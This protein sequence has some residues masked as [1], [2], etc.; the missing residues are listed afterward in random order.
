MNK[1][2]IFIISLSVILVISLVLSLVVLYK[3]SNDDIIQKIGD[4]K[5]IKGNVLYEADFSKF[6]ASQTLPEGYDLAIPVFSENETKTISAAITKDEDK[7]VLNLSSKKS[8]AFLT[9]PEIKTQDYIFEAELVIKTEENATLGIVND[10]QGG[11]SVAKGATICVLRLNKSKS[12]WSYYSR[13]VEDWDGIEAESLGHPMDNPKNGDRVKLKLVSFEN[14]NYLFVND[15]LIATYPQPVRDAKT[16]NVGFFLSD[17]QVNIEKV[18]ITSAC[19][20]KFNLNETAFNVNTDEKSTGLTFSASFDKNNDFYKASYSKNYYYSK[21]TPIKFGFFLADNTVEN[22]ES[23]SETTKNVQSIFFTEYTENDSEINFTYTLNNIPNDMFDKYYT[24]RAFALVEDE[25]FYFDTVSFSV[26]RLAN[27]AFLNAN[28]EEREIINTKFNNVK[29]FNSTG[30]KSI[31]F[32]L[33]SDLHYKE[34]MYIS[35]IGDLNYI[36]ERAYNNHASFVISAGDMTNDMIGSPELVKAF[37]NNKYGLGAYNVYGNHE[38]E[39]SGNTMEIVTPTL[40]NDSNAIF[41]TESGKVEDG[42]I[43]YYYT[44]REGFRLI[45]LDSNYYIDP[46]TN[47]WVHNPTAYWGPLPGGIRIQSLGPQQLAWLEKVLLDAAEKDIPCIVTAHNSFSGKIGGLSGDAEAVRAL[48]KKANTKNPGTVIMSINGHIH[49]DSNA[50]DDGIF[51]FNTNTVRNC[52]WQGNA[53]PHY[54]DSHT[55]IKDVYDAEGNYIES[56]ETPLDTPLCWYSDAPLSAVV[57]V[58]ENGVIEVE[59]SKAN[60]LYGIKPT[61]YNPQ[62]NPVITGGRFVIE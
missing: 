20:L 3:N 16:D 13:A 31:T 14:Y 55:Y 49:S 33:F 43:G 37:K 41:G 23:L 53:E 48:Y 54:Y 9:L 4:I 59:G 60:W 42:S 35:S 10:M 15:K 12:I 45:F 29:G 18:K 6:D 24:V 51:Y 50:M 61:H 58:Y 36:L 47:E 2:P 27:E 46:E 62:S 17:G 7:N 8:D 5:F 28:E 30:V 40:T 26:L 21:K 22:F 52:W 32:G 11:A 39:S 34:G 44:D 19:S 56:V 57:T 25:Y 38:L 1:K